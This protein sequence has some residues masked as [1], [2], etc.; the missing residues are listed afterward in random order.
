LPFKGFV[1]YLAVGLILLVFQTTISPWLLPW[2]YYPD[3][4]LLLIINL[5]LIAPLLKGAVLAAVLGFLK[6]AAGGGTLGLTPFVFFLIFLAIRYARQNLDPKTPGYLMLFIFV[7]SLAGGGLTWFLIYI[8]G[9]P[10]DFLSLCRSGPLSVYL[11]STVVTT[12]VGPIFF[13][14]FDHLRTMTGVAPEEET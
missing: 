12:L 10:L 8:L 14:V 1:V 13:W 4:T 9:E 6:D 3:L 11:I 2:G 7:F 5:G